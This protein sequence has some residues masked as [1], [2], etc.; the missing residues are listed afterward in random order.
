MVTWCP[1]MTPRMAVTRRY[2]RSV[3]L[4]VTTSD[5]TLNVKTRTGRRAPLGELGYEKLPSWLASPDSHTLPHR[6]N[7]VYV[8]RDEDESA[9]LGIMP[10]PEAISV[11]MNG[12]L[13]R[14]SQV[15]ITTRYLGPGSVASHLAPSPS[16]A[17]MSRAPS[18]PTS[19]VSGSHIQSATLEVS[20]YLL[21][22]SERN[23]APTTSRCAAS[24]DSW[25]AT[26]TT[27]ARY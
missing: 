18:G 24:A 12:R 10:S 21:M 2:L 9:R 3:A 19:S 23:S 7:Q 25:Q 20:L 5:P 8:S 11:T 22:W 13:D 27:E 15:I 1:P 4:K 14:D 17:P 26:G 6:F 16:I